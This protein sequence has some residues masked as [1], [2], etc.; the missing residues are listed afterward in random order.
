MAFI[1]ADR[2]KEIT[3]TTGTG[4]I[5]LG[6]TIDASKTFSAA[7][8]DGN[9]TYYCIESPDGNFEVGVGTYTSSS[10]TF[11]RDTVISSTNSG[12]KI[13][14]V[15]VSNVFCTQPGPKSVF[16]NTVGLV[17]GVNSSFQGFAF[18]D[19]TVQ[20]TSATS[21]NA[22]I[23]M[24]RQSEGI[25]F[26][27]F[28][29]NAY[30]ETVSLHLE[31]EQ[32][33]RFKLGLRDSPDG[34]SAPTYGYLFGEQGYAGG[35]GDSTSEFY[36]A[37]NNGFWIKHNSQNI[38]NFAQDDGII[39]Q[40]VS[41]A[42]PAFTVKGNAAQ[43][44]DLQRWSNN[45][46]TTLAKVTKEGY[47]S[48][49]QI[50]APHILFA[51]GSTQTS[52][53]AVA[54]G[55]NI[56][57][58]ANDAGYLTAHPS[59]SAASS[60]NNSTNVF[61]QDI[62][63]DSNGHITAIG[64]ASAFEDWNINSD[65]GVPYAIT[66]G[67]ILQIVGGTNAST[68][69][70][71]STKVLTVNSTDTN[72]TYTA[73]S[74]L[75]L[76]GTEFS[77]PN[78][79]TNTAAIP[80]SG[81]HISGVLQPQITSNTTAIPASGY[82]ISGVLQ[83]QITNLN[84]DSLT[85]FVANEHIDWTSDQGSTNIHTGN[86]D[87][88]IYTA[89]SGIELQ[90]TEFNVAIS[91][92]NIL[93]TNTPTNNYVPSYVNGQ[94]T[95]VANAG[96]GGSMSSFIVTD[97]STPQTVN[98]GETVTFADGTGAEFV[99]SATNTVT[100][101]SVDSEIVHDNLSGFVANEHIDWTASSAGTIHASNYT[102]TNTQLSQEQVE[103][104]VGGML[105][106]T[107][108][109]IT[110][111]Y[112]DGTG[113][114]DFVVDNDLSNYDNSSSGFIT[115][116]LTE[117]QVEDFVGGMLGGT[118]TGITVTYQDS[119]HDIDFVVADTTVAGDSGST[120]ITPGDTLT[121]AGG[122]NVTTA[123]AGD[124]LTI[125]ATDTNTQLTQEQVEDFVGGMLDGD[126]TFITVAYDDTDGNIDFTVPV[127][128][129]DAMTSNSATHLATQ[130]SIKAYVDTEITDL[131]G[132]AP[133]ALDTLNELAAAIG[134]DANY[135]ATITTALGL[136]AP[137]A[138]PTFTGT[139]AIPNVANLETAVVANT[140]KVTNATH[141]GD[142]TGSTALTIAALAV[143]T[144]MIAADAVTGAK[145]ADDAIDSEHYAD[146]SIGTAHIAD[147]AV[148]ADKLAN[149]SVTAGS[150][151]A[152]DI[153][154]DAQG[155]VTAAANGSGGGGGSGDIT[156]VVAGVGLSGGASSG[157]ATLTV[158][159][160]EFSDV[161]PT[162]GDKLA[163]LDSDGS[164]E[165][166]TTIASLATLFAGAG[167]TATNSVIAVDTLNQNT[168]GSAATLTT[169]RA[170]AVDGDVTG[171]ANF[172]GSAACTITTTL[173]TNAII[174]ANITDLNVTTA[175]IAAD[176]ITGAKIADDAIV[177]AAIADDAVLTAH[178]A[179][180]QITAALMADNSI[181]S[182]MYVDGSINTAHIG[183]DQ[184]T[185]DKLANSINSA[186]AAN[187]S[188]NTNVST[189]LG[190]TTSTTTVIVTSSD[191]TNATIPVATTSIGGVMSKAMF[192]KLDGIE[193][194][195]TADQSNAEI[196]TAVEAATDSNVFTDDDHSKLNAIEASADVTSFVLEDGG[197]D[198]VTITKDKEVKF[199]G[200][201]GLTINWTD[202]SPGSDTDPY[203]LTFTIG[204]LDQDT[205]GTAAIATAV[206]V[207]D[208][209]SDTTCFPLFVTTAT[210]DQAPKSGSNL[211]FNS[212]TGL[213]TATSLGGT[214][215][216]AAQT[217]ITSVG[218]LN[219]GS[220]T[221]GFGSINTGAS[222][223]TTTGLISGG[224][225]DIDNVLINGTTIGH[226]DDTDLIT[227]A[228]GLVTVDGEISVT[229]LDIGGTNVTSTAAE[230]NIL[231]GVT[232]TAA[233]LNILD[234]VT[235]TAAELNILDG[236]TS[237]AA[238]LNILDGVT[239]TATELNYLDI[240]TLGTA[241]NS[242]AFTRKGDGTATFAG[243]TI[244]DLG[245]VT[246]ADINGGTI[247]GVTIG[248]NS[249][250]AGT[251]TSITIG[252]AA[253]NETELEMLDGIT[254]GTAAASKAVVLDG[255][256]NIATIGTIGCGAI[257][258]TG[259][260]SFGA[261][262][263]GDNDITD[264]GNIAL[265]SITAD[266]STITITGNT[267]FADGSY[268]FDIAS[269][270]ATNGLKLGGTLVTAT[271]AELNILD[272]V[273]ST[274]AELN[275]LDGVTSTAAEL[276]I[277]DGVTASAADINLI[278][279]I[280]N[281]TVIASKAII[282]DSNKDITGGRN[283]TISGTLEAD[284]ITVGGTNIVTGSLITTLGTISA[285]VWQGTAIASAYIA[286]NSITLAKLAGGTDGT[287]ITF[288]AAGDPVAVGPGSD[289]QVLTSTGAGS[290]PAFEDAGG[291][292]VSAVANGADNRVTTFSSSTALNGEANLTFDG[293][294]LGLTGCYVQEAV[295]ANDTPTAEDATITLDLNSGNYHNIS[296]GADVTKVEFTNA[297]RGQRFILRITQHASSAKTVAW[298]NVDSAAMERLQL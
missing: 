76:A 234:G 275:I 269:H 94:I 178:I 41:A 154:V 20:Y 150:Y 49:V 225:L 295:P 135:A 17:S 62:T 155:R 244:A 241:E 284:A 127:K 253:I 230:L 298:T 71:N 156:E 278:D 226:T 82:V 111:T 260:S 67:N 22:P 139:V 248:G 290:P 280:T 33:P 99:T 8:G 288:D 143:E 86:Y 46:S 4:T 294:T 228:N 65:D 167:L 172:D 204:T 69:Y 55:D 79:V 258:S 250:G 173:A 273:T 200:A 34:N 188:K 126:E 112:Q 196:R 60:S 36:I 246:T 78:V 152:A 220:I 287:I 165:Q 1:L 110:V 61:I 72:T 264:V 18:P 213:L 132:G 21:G 122:T 239:A 27:Y 211:T 59:I 15:G 175:K 236:V 2:V 187:T 92:D 93:A 261:T 114:I 84:H 209:S 66:D 43:A 95:W 142:V 100:V 63:L 144:G 80:A 282:T 259:S 23:T 83:S 153:T 11:S 210:G 105:G 48:G 125:T 98:D 238:E 223:I 242:K 212:D 81:Y 29:N 235:S 75:S 134:D 201:G 229:T 233:E 101:N 119:T 35:V 205:A 277:L 138:S 190:V 136:K 31:N 47:I 202:T 128:D 276:N 185:A 274:A 193:A 108:T 32:F 121:I 131:I 26:N 176:A 103:D 291:G 216:T 191:G 106:G 192:D 39:F 102:D 296:L 227:L 170:I 140:A 51:D 279:G 245:T 240:T 203:D 247:D 7:I 207:A 257:T 159:L 16:I 9:S 171:T 141:T 113:D 137:I 14:L 97:G 42:S 195:A 38:S 255:S 70:N 272:G 266:G 197:G 6:G 281:G 123:M 168:T 221:S 174:T 52:A 24:Q 158:D 177:S 199:T 10:N 120:G 160:S 265:D 249:A 130:Q 145:I 243:T 90:G 254:A 194:S 13:S 68:T 151:T 218:A 129:E 214:L 289:G 107:E 115:A 96:G 222:A 146:G 169:A 53:A 58:F 219:G 271:A 208:E 91:G 148:T 263:F 182:D 183:D 297:N 189:D 56:S 44:A 37:N 181:D 40:N 162:N 256:K 157:S 164:T 292:A 267:T 224:S 28:V 5:T 117:E 179:D 73:G 268:D 232:S 163:T 116:T 206:T 283:I 231:D 293:S 285:G 88:T 133:G 184:V 104:F 89:G 50:H 252:S 118:E 237:T 54:S 87:N 215:T 57:I 64:T 161:T 25:L 251:F 149:T 77:A 3:T 45:S 12:S 19:G 180:D 262:S 74:G 30:D 217:N 198:E 166:L 286:D 85:G 270:D 186:I 109:L 147:D 124:T